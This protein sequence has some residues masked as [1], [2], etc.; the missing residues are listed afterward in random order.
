[1]AFSIKSDKA[2]ELARE[3]T[4]LTG[5]SL[6]AAVTEALRERL[7]RERRRAGGDRAERIH[8]AIE[9]LRQLPVIDDRPTEEII[10]YAEDGLPA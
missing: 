9:R 10:G 6:T 8:A 7:E 1:M 2:D 4:S 3:L 5:E